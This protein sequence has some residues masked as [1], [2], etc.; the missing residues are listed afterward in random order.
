MVKGI[1]FEKGKYKYEYIGKEVI[2]YIDVIFNISVG[3]CFG[4]FFGIR[5]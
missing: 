1:N 5:V 3:W 4:F 2:I